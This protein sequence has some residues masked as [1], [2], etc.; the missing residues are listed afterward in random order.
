[1][2]LSN[3]E[4]FTNK[5]IARL[6]RQ[7]KL[8]IGG[9]TKW[10]AIFFSDIRSFTAISETMRP[11]EV[12]EFLNDYMDRMVACVLQTGGV[13]DKFIGD[14]VMAHWGAVDS[15]GSPEAD[16]WNCVRAAL[17]MRAA[18]GSYNE[19][20]GGSDKPALKIGKGIN[21]GNV[22]AGQIGSEEKLEFT[23]VGEAVNLANKT[24]TFNKPFGTET[25]ISESVY[26]LT[27]DRLILKEMPP[28]LQNGKRVRMFALINVRSEEDGLAILNDLENIPKTKRSISEIFV[29]SKGPKTLKELR[30][31]LGIP[32]PDLSRVNTSEEEKKYSVRSGPVAHDPL[33]KNEMI[34]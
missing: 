13:I 29:G 30:S 32:T 4:K 6:A 24:E 2:M 19:D 17:M 3:F 12:V 26:K 31:L 1:M 27:G 33:T 28:I 23:I 21:A 14:A 10:A 7:G 9:E 11:E 16:A 18:L 15:A 34:I 5:H 8:A 22:V 20:R 25:L